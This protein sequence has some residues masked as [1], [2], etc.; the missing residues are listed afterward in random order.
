VSGFSNICIGFAVQVGHNGWAS[1]AS[2]N[3]ADAKRQALRACR[4]MGLR[5]NLGASFCDTVK[6]VVETLICTHPIF[7]EEERLRTSLFDDP[8]NVQQVA[9]AIAYLHNKYCRTVQ[10]DLISDQ[11]EHVVENCY[12]YSGMYRGE[13]V[14]WGRC[15][16]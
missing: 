10:D 8:N 15:L 2:A 16:E 7:T 4:A 6:E 5:C 13:R 1:R 14:Y 3:L 9:A 12:Q 11:S